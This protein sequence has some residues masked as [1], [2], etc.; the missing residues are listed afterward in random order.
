M[1]VGSRTTHIG[2]VLLASAA[3]AA[4][5]P[6]LAR[7]VIDH[8]VVYDELLHILAARGIVETG[9]PAIAG[10][11]YERGELYT[12]LVSFALVHFGDTPVAARLPALAGGVVSVFLLSLW[13]GRKAGL[14]AGLSAGLLLCVVP[15]TLDVA[16]FAR[17][18]TLHALAMLM[19]F[20]ASFEACRPHKPASARLGWS[21][22]ALALL[23][24]GWHLQE[25]TLIAAVAAV[26]GVLAVLIMTHWTIVSAVVRS[27]PIAI[28]ASVCG[29]AAIGVLLLAEFGF[30]DKFARAP[31]WAAG[32]AGKYHYYLD[33]ISKDLPLLWPLLPAAVFV[34][35]NDPRTRRVASFCATVLVVS[36]VIHSFAGAKA[37]RYLYYV[38]P[39]ACAAWG[40]AVANIVARILERGDPVAPVG[41]GLRRWTVPCLMLLGLIMSQEGIRTM[42]LVAGR[43]QPTAALAYGAEAD[44]G[45]AMPSLD[46][47]LRSADIV[48]TSNAMKALFFFG[49]YDYELNASIVQ[50]TDTDLE[51]GVDARTGERAIGTAKSVERVLEMPGTALVVLEEEKIGRASGVPAD[52]V[53]VIQSRCRSVDLSGTTGIRAWLCPRRDAAP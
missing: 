25:T 33:Q 26:V 14:L 11:M 51:F 19:M 29:L 44:W 12:R 42:R 32:R 52:A 38:L 27:Y 43:L 50:E 48:V 31:L 1:S 9:L 45:P 28:L 18:Y 6:V 36:L 5:L 7:G 49:R 22:F 23:P 3:V 20:A 15:A 24:L 16:V 39:M 4:V 37:V 21:V 10:G 2:W 35:V 30:W 17:F 13:V 8:V 46:Q 47:T 34:G 40:I 53:A 41:H